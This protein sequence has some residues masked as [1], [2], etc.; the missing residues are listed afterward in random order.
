MPLSVDSVPKQRGFHFLSAWIRFTLYRDRLTWC[1]A[2]SP[3]KPRVLT[4]GTQFE[5][6]MKIAMIRNTW[7]A[8][9]PQIQE[10]YGSFTCN[11]NTFSA[12]EKMEKQIKGT[13]GAPGDQTLAL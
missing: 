12:G 7:H 1:S 13:C 8:S 11:K 4:E 5:T 6:H 10:K 9:G 2:F 3:E